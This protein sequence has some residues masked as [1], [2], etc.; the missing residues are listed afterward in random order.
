MM[1]RRS[2]AVIALAVSATLV[3]GAQTPPKAPAAPNPNQ[4]FMSALTGLN[5]LNTA[6]LVYSGTG[7]AAVST[8]PKKPA[9]LA[10]VKKY[11]VAINYGM[12]MSRVD[13]ER[14]TKP[15]RISQY[16]A[17]GMAWDVVDGKKPTANAAAAV[18]RL[19]QIFMTPQGAVQGAFDPAGKRTVAFEAGPDGTQMAAAT[20]RAGDTQLKAYVDG[21]G[22]IARVQTLPG[23]PVL[24]DTIVEFL[25]SDYKDVD[26]IKPPA[27]K[28]PGGGAY[29][30]IPF[31]SRIVQKVGGQ[32]VLDLT[33]TEA[34]PNAGLYLEVPEAIEKAMTRK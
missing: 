7:T 8:D 25:Y 2:L 3:L 31:P 32:T 28:P 14:D 9:T 29:A 5:A 22:M 18:E 24:G 27:V 16:Y 4:R 10:P 19:R 34:K 20:F 17:N 6:S 15:K 1:M 30:G 33:L 11:T 23:D 12:R 26:T 21:A 13:I